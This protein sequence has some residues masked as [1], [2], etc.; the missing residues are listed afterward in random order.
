MFYRKRCLSQRYLPQALYRRCRSRT[1]AVY[2]LSCGGV[3]AVGFWRA[4]Q[5]AGRCS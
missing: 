4:A 5:A 1:G 2:L 3:L